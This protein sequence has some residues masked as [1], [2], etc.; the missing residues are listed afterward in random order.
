MQPFVR[1]RKPLLRWVDVFQTTTA[2]QGRR[3]AGATAARGPSAARSAIFPVRNVAVG[4]GAALF[5]PPAEAGP[6][7]RATPATK[8]ATV[9][10]VISP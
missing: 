7:R 4:R 2:P 9:R 10:M 3:F 6:V 8:I 1:R 5:D